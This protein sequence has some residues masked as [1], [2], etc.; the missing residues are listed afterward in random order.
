MGTNSTDSNLVSPYKA[1]IFDFVKQFATSTERRTILRGFL[2]YRKALQDLGF[3]AGYQ[4]LD[5]SFCSDIEAIESRPPKDIDVVT[6][7]MR[8]TNAKT[9]AE[10]KKLM[11][12][13]IDLFLPHK[14][15]DNYKVDG[16]LVDMNIDPFLIV[17]KASY[18]HGVFGHQRTTSLWK[19]MV[20][21]ELG[22]RDLDA[23]KHLDVLDDADAAAAA[24]S[25]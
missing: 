15:Q 4:W 11:F 8:P 18:W 17:E 13:N 6:Y 7:V 16:Y 19:G 3:V 5:G 22:C 14:T 25:A 10:L 1:T 9:A 12:A 23:I 20:R 21:I 2:H 24:A